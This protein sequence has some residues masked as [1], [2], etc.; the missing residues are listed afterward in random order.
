MKRITVHIGTLRVHGVAP[1]E[2]HGVAAGLEAELVRLLA[3]EG[4][5]EHL[6]RQSSLEVLHVPRCELPAG[7]QPERVGVRA[8]RA[9]ARSFR[10]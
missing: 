5:A 3:A 1:G 6:S 10:R 7:A 4:F 2:H 8:A 9:I